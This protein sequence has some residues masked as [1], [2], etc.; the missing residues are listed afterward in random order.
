MLLQL[1]LTSDTPLVRSDD[2]DSPL[3]DERPLTAQCGEPR[4]GAMIESPAGAG[5]FCPPPPLHQVGLVGLVRPREMQLVDF[6]LF[7]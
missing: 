6:Q 2:S 7:S 1:L 4:R 5:T 3:S